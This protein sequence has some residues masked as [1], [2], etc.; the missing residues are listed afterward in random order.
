[1]GLPG[2]AVRPGGGSSC[3]P[4]AKASGSPPDAISLAVFRH[5]FSAVAEEMGA[6]L[7]RTAF[8]PNIKERRDYSCA[9]FD[10]AGRMIAQAAHIPVHLGAMPASVE[11]AL[12]LGP[13]LPGDAVLL[14]DPFAGGTHLPD[15]TLVTPVFTEEPPANLLGF[16]ASR[17]HHADV[18]GMSPGSMPLSTELYQEGLIIPPVKLFDAGRRNDAIWRLLLAN[19]RT[20]DERDGDLSAQIA[21]AAVGARRLRELAGHYGR[22]TVAAHAETLLHYAEALTRA[23]IRGLPDGMYPFVDCLDDDG[24]GNA[25]LPIRVA[26]T[27]AG[28]S[29]TVDFTGT[30]PE[31]AGSLNAVAAITRSACLYCLRCLIGSDGPANDG[32]FAPL[33]LI[34]PERTLVN[35]RH[36][37]AVAAGNV[38]TSQ[39]IV[40]AIF[41]ALAQAAPDR[42]PAAS[43]GTMNNTVI[44]GSDPR[45]GRPFT[46]YETVG[47]GGGALP[48]LDG[49]SGRHS[50]MTNTLN[51]PVEALETAYPLRVLAYRLRPGSGGG[52]RFRGGDGLERSL[53]FLAPATATVMS[54]RRLHGPYGLAGGAAGQ[55][56]RNRL[57]RATG[58]EVELPGK[59]TLAVQ[60][61]D[62]L[63]VETP[64]GGGWGDAEP[65]GEG[66]RGSRTP[67]GQGEPATVEA[68]SGPL[69]SHTASTVATAL[70]AFLADLTIGKSPSTVTTYRAAL[71]RFLEGLAPTTAAGS[72]NVPT[73]PKQG[74]PSRPVEATPS[75]PRPLAPSLPVT[76]L[77]EEHAVDFARR[78]VRETPGLPKAT[79]LTYTTAVVRFYAFLLREGYRADLP[80]PRLAE[81]LKAIRGKRPRSL[82]R[83][84]EDA[85]LE[86]ILSAARGRPVGG[87]PRLA[88]LRLR[89]IAM[90][91]A[92]RGSGMRV[93]ELVG[94]RRGDLMRS[95]Q[96]ARVTGKGSKMR[97]IYFTPNAWQCLE[98]YFAARRAGAAERSIAL[99][100]VFT[101]HDRGAGDRLLPLS[102]KSV[103]QIVRTL[104]I[105]AEQE[106]AGVTPHRFRAWFATH[107]VE[108][109]GDLAATQ[110]LLGHESADTTRVYTRVAAQRLRELHRRAFA[111]D[112]APV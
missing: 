17:A 89:D 108:T 36:P 53:Q 101:R 56:G 68:T 57:R 25:D 9:V 82:P 6:A 61:G 12:T 33:Q 66:A 5:L 42:V 45:T 35:A 59:V 16:V 22:D 87:E 31:C 7:G 55:R 58:E 64:G 29:L 79:L 98:T 47:G 65:G 97:L 37:H 40:D 75:P 81:R 34:L 103:R 38:E 93:S 76:L 2:G 26:V 54:E 63:I 88:C 21:A 62:V 92:M 49:L 80:L 19:T 109:T 51:T 39:R 46:Y 104:G 10:A 3:E 91:E 105:A 32:S 4:D 77:T 71:R 8:S 13:F 83:V 52:G 43:Q 14:N 73:S 94:L 27:I 86:A 78:L 102:T 24:Q 112:G 99:Q 95:Q 110:D 50:H 72:A 15:L 111:D 96:A 90:L 67:V 85:V 28:D 100:P 107:M 106:D 20:P 84:P 11:A 48:D 69:P 74:A 60:P 44:G 30:A 70:D 23:A 18:G 1:M 41:G